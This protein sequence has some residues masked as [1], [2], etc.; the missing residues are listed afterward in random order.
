M[1]APG[2][3]IDGRAFA[4]TINGN[5]CGCCGMIH[6]A[7][8]FYRGDTWEITGNLAYADGSPFNLAAGAAVAW[9]VEDGSG[10]V[11]VSG[12]LAGGQIAAVAAVPG[13]ILITIPR[14]TTDVLV[15]GDYTDQLQATDPTGYV[16]TQWT[17]PVNV[18]SSFFA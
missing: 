3:I 18:R 9:K 2:C 16:S 17:G 12:T 13:Q 15:P 5:A 6:P 8:S 1:S 7:L 10:N 14:A 4:P 11:I